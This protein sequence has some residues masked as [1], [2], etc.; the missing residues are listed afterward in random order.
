MKTHSTSTLLGFAFMRTIALAI[1]GLSLN[2]N[3]VN[4]QNPIE[5]TAQT[6]EPPSPSGDK[7]YAD[8][9]FGP[10]AYVGQYTG[11]YWKDGKRP[12][13]NVTVNSPVVS[14][15]YQEGG[16]SVF[17]QIL[18]DASGERNTPFWD[19]IQS[20][21]WPLKLPDNVLSL[22]EGVAKLATPKFPGSDKELGYS[23]YLSGTQFKNGWFTPT[24]PEFLAMQIAGT[25]GKP[26]KS[27]QVVEVPVD[28]NALITKVANVF[29]S[30]LIWGRV[31]GISNEK[32]QDILIKW[33]DPALSGFWSVLKPRERFYFRAKF[34]PE[35]EE[36]IQKL[37]SPSFVEAERQ[38]LHALRQN[39]D[40][41]ETK[42]FTVHNGQSDTVMILH[43]HDFQTL[44]AFGYPRK[45]PRF[46]TMLLRRLFN[47]EMTS[48]RMLTL[49]TKLRAS[50]LGWDQQWGI[51]A[52]SE[53]VI[54]TLFS[55]NPV[56]Q[57]LP[58]E[59]DTYKPGTR[60]LNPVLNE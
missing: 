1:L 25:L 17:A 14:Y 52:N 33:A 13:D 21:D 60:S 40:G 34:L 5:A 20:K 16:P 53:G 28:E 30:E 41:I 8:E 39:D 9:R 32:Y 38:Y 48:E 35:I 55:P 15:Y 3:P 29:G 37:L 4:A 47:A 18:G 22:V 12:D 45:H 50:V 59:G 57:Y 23:V 7:G 2:L 44:D 24:W 54:P 19:S 6:A 51:D 36:F 42:Q 43:L 10:G 27:T 31:R 58:V 56:G 46:E 11:N 49:I 26:E